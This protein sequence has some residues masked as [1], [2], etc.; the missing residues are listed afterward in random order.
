MP[1]N[2][3]LPNGPDPELPDGKRLVD[4]NIYM[5]FNTQ[6]GKE[7]KE[8]YAYDRYS[9]IWCEKTNKEK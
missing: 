6:R 7:R 8:K 4:T 9:I 5:L 2:I 1:S 3:T